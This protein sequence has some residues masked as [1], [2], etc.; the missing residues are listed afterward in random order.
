VEDL[1]VSGLESSLSD[2]Q[3]ELDKLYT[4]NDA[5][6]KQIEEANLLIEEMGQA[7]L[8]LELK[9]N[10]HW[11]PDHCRDVWKEGLSKYKERE[12]NKQCLN[13]HKGNGR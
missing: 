5:L 8:K 4:E 3:K 11:I 6:N 10:N 12:K 2:A 9:W 1:F 7:L 13:L